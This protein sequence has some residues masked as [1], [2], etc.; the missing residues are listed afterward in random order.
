MKKIFLSIFLFFALVNITLAGEISVRTSIEPSE[1]LIGEQASLK[2]ELT[3]DKDDKVSWPQF[4]DTIA[5][6]VSII[7]KLATDTIS[8]PDNRISITSEYLVSSYDSGFYYIPEFVFETTSQKVTSNPVGL[9]VNTVQVN[10]QTDDIHAE[11]DI[12]SAPFSWIELAQWSGIGLAIILII[13]IIVLLL[14]RFVFK[15]KVTIIPEEPEVILPAHVVALEKL[16]Q[17]KTEK[18]WQQGQIKQFYTQLTDVIRE[19]LSRAYSINAMEMTTDE[20][21]ALVKK[22]KD[23]DEIRI[24]LKEMLELSDLVKF[25]K[26]IPLENEN[27]KAVLDAFMIVEKTTKEPEVEEKQE[28][29]KTS[30]E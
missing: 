26:F 13:A 19:Y 8:L 11:K 27:E 14:M 9:T 3:Q 22:N 10:E 5:T 16:E 21:V 15:K 28:T 1:I 2:I 24:V 7:E 6:N 25:A 4:S 23:L 29:E 12:M 20:I 30:E 18:I 17:I